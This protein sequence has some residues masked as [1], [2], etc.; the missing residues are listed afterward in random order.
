[1]ILNMHAGTLLS[2]LAEHTFVIHIYFLCRNGQV[3]VVAYIIKK[4]HCDV[5]IVNKTKETALHVACR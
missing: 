1:M 4:C 2:I 5:N 3:K